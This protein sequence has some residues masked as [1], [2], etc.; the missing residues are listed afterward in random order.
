MPDGNVKL[1]LYRDDTNGLNGGTWVKINELIDNGTNF[2][3][4]GTACKSGIDPALRLTSSDNRIGSET[5]KPNL[6]VYFRSD[7]VGTDGLWYKKASVREITP[8]L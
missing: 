7:G 8:P 6:A 2:G 4:G 3:V 1:E 5:G